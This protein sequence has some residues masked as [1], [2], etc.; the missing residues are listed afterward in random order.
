M[1]AY[2]QVLDED[3]VEHYRLTGCRYMMY[4]ELAYGPL[5]RGEV[6]YT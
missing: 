2:E 3:G 1:R 4:C 5:R 6:V